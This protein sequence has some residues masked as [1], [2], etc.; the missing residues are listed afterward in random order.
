MP[1]LGMCD[2]H[3]CRSRSGKS[4]LQPNL[5][6]SASPC[7]YM[8]F[9]EKAIEFADWVATAAVAGLVG[10]CCRPCAQLEQRGKGKH[11]QVEDMNTAGTAG[12]SSAHCTKTSARS[13][14]TV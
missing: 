6:T 9:C 8:K 7:T 14:E 1:V 13:Y 5:V 4:V 3:S 12:L 10:Q 11:L 2:S